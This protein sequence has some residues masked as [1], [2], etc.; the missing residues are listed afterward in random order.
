MNESFK[1]H[2]SSDRSIQQEQTAPPVEPVYDTW[3]LKKDA[4]AWCIAPAFDFLSLTTREVNAWFAGVVTGMLEAF[5]GLVRAWRVDFN[6]SYREDIEG[7]RLE[8]QPGNSYQAYIA[9]VLKTIKAFPAPIDTINI[10]IDL[11]V[12]V[13]TE[14]SPHKPVRA[15]VR[16]PSDFA[17]W[18]GPENKKPYLCFE[19][20]HTLFR[21][22]SLYGDND[23]RE[24]YLLNQPVL[25]QALRKWERRFGTIRDVEGMSGIYEYGFSTELE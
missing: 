9:D 6:T 8:W 15:W 10:E 4:G 11:C 23:N 7:V 18:G 14:Q 21:P 12:Y 3:E 22:E 24:L 17:I 25:E 1:P 5:G 16:L 20:D 19:I 13:R 2:L